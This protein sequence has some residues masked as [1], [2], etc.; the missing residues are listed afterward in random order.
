MKL[1]SLPRLIDIFNINEKR[2]ESLGRRIVT[3]LVVLQR[4]TVTVRWWMLFY[5]GGCP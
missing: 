5:H 4:M 1:A 2:L 3:I